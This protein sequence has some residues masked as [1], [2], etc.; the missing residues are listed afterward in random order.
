ML[1]ESSPGDGKLHSPA[2]G[3][4]PP[5]LSQKV[6]PEDR[7]VRRPDGVPGASASAGVAC[8]MFG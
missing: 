1:M 6:V 7:V 5:G 3:E 8:L 2:T 4:R